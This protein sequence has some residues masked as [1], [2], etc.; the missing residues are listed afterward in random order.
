[1]PS[2]PI[3][4]TFLT[5]Q[6]AKA[7]FLETPDG[8]QMSY[9]QLRQEVAQMAA[10]LQSEGVTPGDR[11]LC[12]IAKSP[13]ALVLYLATVAAGGVFVPL[14]TAYTPAELAYF[15]ED[16]AP[17]LLII[18]DSTEAARAVAEAQIL[19]CVTPAAL[20]AAQVAPL[21]APV[22]RVPDDLAAILYT[23][24]TTGRSKGAML[25]HDN[26]I[27]NAKALCDHWQF[28][29]SD[30]LL[31]ALPVFHTHGLFVATNTVLL[32]GARMI[33]HGA[34]DIDQIAKDL[35][36]ASVIMGVPTFYSR[37]LADPRF[38]RES[39]AHMRLVIS[40]SAPLLA[41][42]HA[43]FEA[44]TGHAILERYGMTETNMITSNPYRGPRRAGTVGQPL[45]G[46]SVRLATPDAQGIGGIEVRGPNVTRGYWQ[47]AEKTKESFTADGWFITGDLGQFDEGGYLSIVGREKD[48][49]ISGGFNIYPKE[50][51]S[52]I[53]ALP[54]V[55][56]SAVFGVAHGDLGEVVA[57][58]I[59][60][61][62]G[63]RLD[64]EAVLTALGPQLARFKLPRELRFVDQLPRN[65]MGK[66]QK[67]ELRK[68]FEGETP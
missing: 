6:P 5:R 50:I 49:V 39:M 52:L 37:M 34:F 66:V 29:T 61:R 35:P 13:A 30:V 17:A 19:R 18:D 26:L 3:H 25:S 65:A 31:H 16:A 55:E 45:Q 62:A 4:E 21:A 48:L 42:T 59:V 68:L 67:A 33:F 32:S 54:E 53:D 23:S 27:S 38:T 57:A 41:D 24:G 40:G 10:A 58:A 43:A 44:R 47:N 11:V 15:I 7:P 46:V 9:A 51:E 60:L 64:A 20:S 2:N 56:E 28:T 8:R 1:M 36:R 12:Q 63:A 14:N 22:P